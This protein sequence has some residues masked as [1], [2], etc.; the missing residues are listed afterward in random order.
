MV[1]ILPHWNWSAGQ[2]VTVFVYTNC[3]SV[4]L[5]LNGSSLGS[6]T[7]QAGGALHLEW[8]VAYAAG[9]L[10]AEGRRAGALVATEEVRTAA[11]AARV[12][13]SADRTSINADGEDLA[14]LTADIVDANGVFVPTA[15]NTVNFSVSGPG[16]LVG[17]DNGNAISLESYKGT[18]RQ[19]FS[20]KCLAIVQ[21]TGAT[22]SIVVTASSSGL[23][24]GSATIATQGSGVPTNTPTTTPTITPTPGAGANLALG[25][26][27]SADSEETGKGNVAA[28]GNDGST[29]TRW[30]A[31]DGNTGH[32]WQVDLGA[33]FSLS[34]SE[35][36]WEF[37]GRV[38][39]YRVEVSSNGTTWTTVVD[40]TANTSTAQTQTD[41]FSATARY[42]RI[43]V[44]GLPASPVTWASFFEFRVFGS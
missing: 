23:T 38:Y 27:A 5:F 7:F 19:A 21:S 13:L 43:T 33:A 6:R 28:N 24:A 30:C 18:S 20:G 36:M 9:T 8:S 3:D 39:R 42:V 35:V 37:S 31:N 44:T 29:T 16:R 4:E 2:T 41:P 40:K 26:P 1:H 22:G 34:R 32:W 14:F 25:K 11:A 15:G 12:A 10:R 17:V